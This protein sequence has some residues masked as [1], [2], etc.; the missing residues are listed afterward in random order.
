MPAF[1]VMVNHSLF[2]FRERLEVNMKPLL[3]KS[4]QMIVHGREL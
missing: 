2:K 3:G 4:S 1:P